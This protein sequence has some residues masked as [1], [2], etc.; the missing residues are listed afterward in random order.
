[1]GRKQHKRIRATVDGIEEQ[2][3]QQRTNS[4]SS[5]VSSSGM[6]QTHSFAKE[7]NL[8][9]IAKLKNA[10]GYRVWSQAVRCLF[11]AK[12]LEDFL[13]RTEAA[14]ADPEADVMCLNILVQLVV[15][16]YSEN[17]LAIGTT[18]KAWSYLKDRFFGDRQNQILGAIVQLYSIQPNS[19]DDYFRRFRIAASTVRA[20]DPL[21]GEHHMLVSFLAYLPREA[22]K[23]AYHV[24]SVQM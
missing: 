9:S 24:H 12:R 22:K 18:H 13:H 4:T 7:F 3:E 11:K 2:Q 20:L 19:I 14:A 15:G 21:Y 8:K 16:N 17:I 6:Q 5:A 1:M 10:K 23:Y